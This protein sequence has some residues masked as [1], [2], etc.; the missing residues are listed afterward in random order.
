MKIVLANGCFDVLHPG[1]IAHLHEA[2]SMGDFLIV[3]LTLDAFVN[4]GPGR[5]I[6]KWPDRAALLRELRCVDLVVPTVHPA[7]VILGCRPAF[8]VKGADYEHV[9]FSEDIISACKKVGTQI[10][11]TSAPKMSTSEIVSKIM[12]L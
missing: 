3:S 10:R 5:P 7:D 11:H 8:F 6:Y 9:A 1:H 12:R 4:K 2:R